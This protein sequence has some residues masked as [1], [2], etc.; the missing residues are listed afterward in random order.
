METVE[1]SEALKLVRCIRDQ[2]N[3]QA[4]SEAL[5]MRDKWLFESDIGVLHF[6]A[7][8]RALLENALIDS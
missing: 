3:P 2:A 8:V 1:M 7:E 6:G 5:G 4:A